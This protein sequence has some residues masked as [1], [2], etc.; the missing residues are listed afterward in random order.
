MKSRN[1]QTHKETKIMTIYQCC[2]E[3]CMRIQLNTVTL[4]FNGK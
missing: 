1:R 3:Q 2:P 4:Y